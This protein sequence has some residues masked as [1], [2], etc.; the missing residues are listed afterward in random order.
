MARLLKHARDVMLNPRSS[1]ATRDLAERLFREIYSFLRSTQLHIEIEPNDLAGGPTLEYTSRAFPSIFSAIFA[2]AFLQ[3]NRRVAA[4]WMCELMEA[5]LVLDATAAKLEVVYLLERC[6]SSAST[7]PEGPD[8]FRDGKLCAAFFKL[9]AEKWQHPCRLFAGSPVPSSYTFSV[10][11]KSLGS[12]APTAPATLGSLGDLHAMVRG[13]TTFGKDMDQFVDTLFTRLKIDNRGLEVRLPSLK[14]SPTLIP[15]NLPLRLPT[16][17]YSIASLARPQGVLHKLGEAAR[18]I[19]ESPEDPEFAQLALEI[20]CLLEP[21]PP[22]WICPQRLTMR[23]LRLIL[24]YQTDLG[25][26]LPLR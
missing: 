17:R 12:R 3:L 21:A 8:G 14:L 25:Q 7:R 9:L 1:R 23:R 22:T 13:T 11:L 18:S 6:F 5:A 16:C 15:V 26:T 19:A 2:Q 4:V 24:E 20:V 10:H